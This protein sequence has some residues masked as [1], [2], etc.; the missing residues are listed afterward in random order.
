MTNTRKGPSHSV[1]CLL[2]PTWPFGFHTYP[3]IQSAHSGLGGLLMMHPGH[4]VP[5]R[6]MS[7]AS[8]AGGVSPLSSTQDSSPCPQLQGLPWRAP[9]LPHDHLFSE[10]HSSQGTQPT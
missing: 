1:T 3:R 10:F 4:G 7:L 6:E 9:H 8:P 5:P 2:A